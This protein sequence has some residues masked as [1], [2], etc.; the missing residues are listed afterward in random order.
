MYLNIWPFKNW[1][2]YIIPVNLKELNANWI[3]NVCSK[4]STGWLTF[5]W[6]PRYSFSSK[7]LYCLVTRLF[8]ILYEAEKCFDCIPIYFQDTITDIDPI[9][10]LT[11]NYATPIF[12][13]NNPPN[14]ISLAVDNDENCGLTL[15]PV[16]WATETLF[17]S[18]QV[19]TAIGS[20]TF[21]AEEA[22]KIYEIC[23]NQK[24]FMALSNY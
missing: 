12:C 2:H 24:H 20:N 1:T 10:R 14:V 21:T 4:S 5:K 16:I 6:K 7:S 19:Q 17:D 3:S 23:Y 8:S 18:K 9:T 11:F 15:E 13:V 22:G